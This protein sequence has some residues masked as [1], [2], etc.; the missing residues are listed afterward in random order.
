MAEYYGYAER[1]ANAYVDWGKLGQNLTETVQTA[2]A[3][4]EKKKQELDDL[5][6]KNYAELANTPTGQNQDINKFTTTLADNQKQYLLQVNKLL[7]AGILKPKDYTLIN[8]NLAEDTK[9]LF[10]NAKGWQDAYAKILERNKNS[11]G[12]KAEL[13]LSADVAAFGK[14]KNI[15]G[16]I[17][18]V[19]GRI[20]VSK[21]ITGP[22]GE[23]IKGESMSMQQLNVLMNQNIDKYKLTEKLSSVVDKLGENQISIFRAARIQANGQITEI[24][25]KSLKA[26]F[27]AAKN[28]FINEVMANPFN[29][30]SILVDHQGVIPGTTTPYRVST[31]PADKGK[32]DVIFYSDPDGDGSYTPEFS[33]AQ[34]K[35]AEEYTTNQ[36]LGL[37]DRE[38]SNQAIS[39]I[40]PSYEPEYLYKAGQEAIEK[41]NAV[42]AWDTLRSGTAQQKQDA[43]NILLGTTLAK[44]E[45]LIDIDLES[46]PGYAL[47]K[48]SD[49]QKDRE[50]QITDDGARWSAI[51]VELHGQNDI[52]KARKA[53]GDSWKKPINTDYTGVRATR[54]GD[55]YSQEMSEYTNKNVS[56]AVFKNNGKQTAANLNAK[57]KDLGFTV[58]GDWKGLGND[59]IVIT[60]PDGSKSGEIPVN[61]TS[62]ISEIE[63]FFN[64]KLDNKRAANVFKR[65]AGGQSTNA[66]GSTPKQG[67]AKGDK[68]FGG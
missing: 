2:Y 26:S 46:K 13:D 22:N 27:D 48:Y 42:G 63:A 16:M 68:I 45:G 15:D 4:R 54:R 44:N 33:A 60:A 11:T 51:G 12:S 20:S 59:Y 32:P 39:P 52:N 36:F 57:F 50:I 10:D 56:S 58:R 38:E 34:R 23:Q 9:A 49:N 30:M 18:P 65:Q 17:N 3:L 31:N 62:T 28:G 5:M 8:Q 55:D 1:D 47:L 29:V 67:G 64:S 25:D 66:G 61:D 24:K 37:I 7:K 41:D 6:Q 43:A 14:F 21:M 35:A 53:A 40:S 19:T